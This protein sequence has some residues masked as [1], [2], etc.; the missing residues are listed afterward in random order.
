MQK[1]KKWIRYIIY[2]IIGYLIFTILFSIAQIQTFKELSIDIDIKT[3]IFTVMKSDIILYTIIYFLIL[4]L[5][6]LYNIRLAK[7]LNKKSEK[8]RKISN[9]KILKERRDISMKKKILIII[10]AI[11]LMALIILGINIVRKVNII[12][13]F[14]TKVEEYQKL[15]NFYAKEVYTIND[16]EVRTD[17][18]WRKDDVSILKNTLDNG[19]IRSLYYNNE[20]TL[21][22][23][24]NSDGTK[25]GAR[26]KR[27]INDFSPG[28]V[29][30]DG[31]YYIDNNLWEAIKA[32]FTTKIT[33]ESFNGKEC[34]KFY[35]NDNW[36][37]FVDKENML[38]IREI[39]GSENSEL[40]DYKIGTVTDEEI[41]FPNTDGYIIQEVNN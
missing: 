1:L 8:I 7:K 6:T 20:E 39:N 13:E 24:D 14:S 5:N 32:A 23:S 4:I 40:V 17:E 19:T 2:F 15:T 28:I 9:E 16:S 31:S 3:I 36:Q 26:F 41:Q 37:F 33:S 29:I 22:L 27:D 30:E 25:V 21:M 38:K 11:V 10:L 18:K 12:S 34:Y 35:I